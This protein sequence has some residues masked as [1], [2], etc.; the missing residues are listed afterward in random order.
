VICCSINLNFT[1]QYNKATPTC[2]K[3]SNSFNERN[4]SVSTYRTVYWFGTYLCS[5]QHW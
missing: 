1:A 3:F 5:L 4:E 2:Q